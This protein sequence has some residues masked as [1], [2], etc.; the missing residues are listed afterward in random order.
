LGLALAGCGAPPVLRTDVPDYGEV[1]ALFVAGEDIQVITIR[2]LDRVAITAVALVLPDGERVPAYSID[3]QRN[4]TYSNRTSIGT[5]G[6]DSVIG[7]GGGVPLLNGPGMDRKTTVLIGQIASTALIRVPDL[8]AYREVW[9]QSKLEIH[10]GFAP[11][12]Q[13]ETL[14]APQPG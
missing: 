1:K 12:D 4:P 13:V 8:E 10:M 11:D 2:A 5:M 14:A 9:P 3:Q 6:T 7:I